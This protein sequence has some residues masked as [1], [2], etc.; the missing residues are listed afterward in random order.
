MDKNRKN[1]EKNTIFAEKTEKCPIFAAQKRGSLAQLVQSIALTRRGSLVRVQ[2]FPQQKKPL[3][4]SGFFYSF[5][6]GMLFDDNFL[7]LHTVVADQTKNVDTW[8]EVHV[9]F[10]IAIDGFAR[11]NMSQNIND[12]NDGIVLAVDFERVAAAISKTLEVFLVA[13]G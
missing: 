3:K 11:K 10:T 1:L 4:I 8:A 9:L 12:L 5:M 13:I 2:Q 6:S 7:G